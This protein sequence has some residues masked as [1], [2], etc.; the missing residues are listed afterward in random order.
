MASALQR[1]R[2]SARQARR[3]LRRQLEKGLK[4]L[5]GGRASDEGIHDAR[6]R[7][8]QARATLRLLRKALAGAE[9]R[10]E[11]QTLR[12]AAQ[13]L[14]SARDA[15]ILLEALDG[16]QQQYRGTQHIEGTQRFR[17][18]LLRARTQARR[19]ALTDATGV[20]RSRRLLRKARARAKHWPLGHDG[21]RLLVQGAVR[22]YAKGRDALADV[23]RERTA[24]RLHRWRK[25]TKYLYLQ[26]ELLAPI[27]SPYIARCARR[28]HRLSDDLGDDHDLAMLHERVAAYMRDFPTELKGGTLLNA[29]ERSRTRLQSRALLRGS[30]LYGGRPARLARR[31]G[32][33]TGR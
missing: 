6:K 20:R 3:I 10:R 26:L 14:S 25:Q 32:L 24:E 13:P 7:I 16:M 18:A 4:V 29:I 5:D 1:R 15:K 33:Q 27:S 22:R 2:S 11:E 17:R 30:R 21:W 12:D 8:K 9:Y 23:N 31:L 28:L 19:H